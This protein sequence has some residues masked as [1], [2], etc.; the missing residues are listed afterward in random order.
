MTTMVCATCLETKSL[1]QFNRDPRGKNGRKYVC[2]KCSTAYSQKYRTS[3]AGRARRAFNKANQSAAKFGVPSDLTYEQV[4]ALFK[5]FGGNCQYT[6]EPLT[7]GTNTPHL[8]H[9]R[10]LALGGHNSIDNVTISSGSANKRK[11]LLPLF[12]F[13]ERDERFTI[14]RLANIIS[15]IAAAR[16]VSVAEIIEEH[17][18][19]KSEFIIQ[20]LISRMPG[21]KVSA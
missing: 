7:I 1:E 5:E 8:E 12:I 13:Y 9:I 11:D 18:R 20:R 3:L 19:L 6:G 15:R 21:R 10:P 16:N 4:F 2:R 17:K 14:D